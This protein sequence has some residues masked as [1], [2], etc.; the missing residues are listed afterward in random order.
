M[1]KIPKIPKD[2]IFLARDIYRTCA[3]KSQ[4]G[5][6]FKTTFL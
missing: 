2:K 1:V 6:V 3:A 5:G 4:S